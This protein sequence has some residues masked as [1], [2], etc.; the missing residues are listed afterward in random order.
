[1]LGAAGLT[2]VFAIGATDDAGAEAGNAGQTGKKF[3]AW[4]N[5]ATDGTITI[6]SPVIEMGQGSTTALPLVFA[7]ELDADWSKVKV[8]S[9]PPK[10]DVYGSHIFDGMMYTADSNA[11]FSYY[12]SMRKKGG[13]V[14]RVLLNNA[15]ARLGVLVSE[16]TTNP[17]TVLH[18]SSG[19]MLTYGEIAEFA[20][21]P[22]PLPEVAEN[23]FKQPSQFRL[24][25][26]DVLRLDL[27]GK[28]N[29]TAQFSIDVQV[30]NMLYG[31]VL[32]APVEG[33]VPDHID[34]AEARAVA[35]VFKV[36][37]MPW[38]VGVLAESPWAAFNG[39]RALE[40]AVTWSRTGWAW[41]FDSDEGI[42]HFADDAGDLRH[43]A[44]LDWKVVGDV[45][46]A[47][48]HAAATF[49]ADYLCDY[50]Y[51]AQMEPL[52]AVASVSPAGDSVEIWCGTQSQTIA[53]EAPAK[54]LGILREKV[55]LND[56][57]LGGAFGRRGNRDADFILDAVFLSKN[58][59]R[60]VKVI[61]MR[62]DDVRNGRFRPMSA[63]HLRAGLDSDGKLIAWH[64]R[65]AVDRVKPAFDLVRYQ[66]GAARD[67]IAMRGADL[68]DYIVP[69]QLI[70]QLYRDTGV[71]TAPFRG[72]GFNANKFATES[73]LDE[74]VLKRG[75]DPIAYRLDMMTDPRAIN[76]IK[77]VREMADWERRRDGRALGFA[78]VDYGNNNSTT[79]GAA[80]AEVS[81]N[82]RTGE[83]KVHEFWCAVDC[84][85]VVQPDNV[86]SQIEGGVVH[87]LGLALTETISIKG[88]VV[89]QS[90]FHDY[91]IPRMHEIPDIHVAVMPPSDRTRPPQPGVGQVATPLVAPAIANAL[92]RLANVRLRR[93]P[94]TTDRVL[95][96]ISDTR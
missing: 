1:M 69:D 38:G 46:S 25:G 44:A 24:I 41:D 81:L 51:H 37:R 88:G 48:A 42:K 7:E 9:A 23:E 59:G 64:H 79:K 18:A 92:A 95:K 47:L 49:E 72:I 19:R 26:T 43:A 45:K 55:K 36:V 91:R 8:L 16:L 34:E 14:R 63:H 87:G 66:L 28:V 33:S 56:M 5:I 29:G 30:P 71:R 76:V 83:I 86:V 35:G 11:M 4:V 60:P 22:D 70:E 10:D 75:G 27:P 67:S 94:F 3:G 68:V 13:G 74:I 78:Y 32:R 12:T 61:W 90:N 15:A 62:E 84:R 52:N 57:L 50:A 2:F 31:A 6:Y 65:V 20:E 93:T 53:C 89:K 77:K 85:V 96:A 80:I 73:F 40:N 21:V 17:S 82:V 58:A 54:L 39:R